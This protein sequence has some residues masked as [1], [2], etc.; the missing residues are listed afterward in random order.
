MAE[1]VYIHPSAVVDAGAILGNGTKIWHFCHV[2]G[3]ASLGEDC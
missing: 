1:A 3:G 2:M